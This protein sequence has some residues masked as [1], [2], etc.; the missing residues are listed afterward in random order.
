MGE[1]RCVF[2]YVARERLNK[3]YGTALKALNT[4]LTEN[5]NTVPSSTSLATLWI[6]GDKERAS[7]LSGSELVQHAI[8]LRSELY[9]ELKWTAWKRYEDQWNL[10]RF[11]SSFAP[12]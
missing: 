8:R 5:G 4:F 2:L 1:A 10:A 6:D 9:G 12:F 3:R 7:P 11:P